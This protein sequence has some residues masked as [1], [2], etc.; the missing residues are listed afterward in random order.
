MKKKVVLVLHGWNLSAK[1]YKNFKSLLEVQGLRVIVPDLP[2][3]GEA[4]TPDNPFSLNDYENFTLSLIKQN[5]LDS[6]ILVGHSFGG[7][8]AIKLAAHYPS[9]IEKLILTGVPGVI[10]KPLQIKIKFFKVLAIIGNK[11]FDLPLLNLLEKN[12]LR[13][14]LY[15]LAGATDYMK[16]QGVMRETFKRIISQ[17]LTSCMKRIR[18]PTLLVWGEADNIT[19][20]AIAKVMKQK[21]NNSKIEIVEKLGHSFIYQNPNRFINI[22]GSFLN[23]K[24]DS[25]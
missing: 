5:N 22:I 7:R 8:I 17:D 2:G 14:I 25:A 10:Q 18:C 20:V 13:K 11:I 23:R 12:I 3:F 4:K 19:P 21:I 6:V 9:L 1:S 24:Y 15:K 16:T